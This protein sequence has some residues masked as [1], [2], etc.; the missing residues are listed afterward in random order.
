MKHALSQLGG[1]IFVCIDAAN[2]ESA[3]KS[4]HMRID[5]RA[6]K[7]TFAVQDMRHLRFYS[8]RHETISHINFLAFMRHCG[9]VLITKP[10]KKI[11]GESGENIRK[12][13]FDVEIAVDS[14]LFVSEYDVLVLFSGDS[15]FDYLLKKLHSQGKKI[16]VISSKNH[17]SHE[18]IKSADVYVDLKSL[19]QISRQ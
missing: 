2:L 9:Y 18:L 5:Y 4:L 19:K 8:V 3:A 14:L 1:R 17:I 12:A 16:V 13:N 10:L 6:L 15:D 7:R 11:T